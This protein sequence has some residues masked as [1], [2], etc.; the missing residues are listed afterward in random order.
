MNDPKHFTPRFRLRTAVWLNDQEP[1][2]LTR[3]RV[4]EDVKDAP[5]PDPDESTDGFI[6]WLERR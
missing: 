3:Y 1:F 4:V 6:L 2:L 5:L